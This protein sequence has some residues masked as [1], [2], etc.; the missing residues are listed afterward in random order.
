MPFERCPSAAES[1]DG[2]P[3]ILRGVIDLV[4]LED[5]GWVIVEYKTDA[6]AKEHLSQL[7]AHYRGQV[8]TYADAWQAIVGEDVRERGL[9]FTTDNQ[10]VT[11]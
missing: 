8:C 1:K 9:L 4:F 7:V 11:V 2:L 3:T 5:N 10:Y 6:G